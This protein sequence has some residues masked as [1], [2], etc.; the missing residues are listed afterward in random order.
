MAMNYAHDA[1]S[2][3]S[4]GPRPR[5]HTH[6]AIL[7]A[8]TAGAPAY[9]LLIPRTP[10]MVLSFLLGRRRSFRADA[11][12]Y[13]NALKPPVAVGGQSLPDMTSGRW[14]LLTNHYHRP[15][16]PSWWI[17]LAIS[18]LLPAEVLWTMTG[19]W[20]YPDRLRANV[21]SPLTRW[22]FARLAACYGFVTMPPM[23][24]RP[25]EAEARAR[26]VRRVLALAT[27]S[28]DLIVALAPEGRDT[29][30]GRMEAPAPGAGR[31]I[32]LLA[33]LHYQL[34]PVGVYEAD[35][36]LWVRF[37]E[38]LILG[39]AIGL[40]ACERETSVSAMVVGAI[41]SCLPDAIRGDFGD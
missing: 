25:W 9:P 40:P 20:T 30:G 37:G 2:H 39:E 32:S 41:A 10:S 8:V 4:Y 3:G 35:G 27:A 16:F 11:Q 7:A 26:S 23:P 1:N 38:P 36:Q 14:L 6:P 22:A 33:R 13:M 34:V 28:P 19:E 18:A 17:A 21:I 29:F 31:F 5:C 24:P 12:A 15:G